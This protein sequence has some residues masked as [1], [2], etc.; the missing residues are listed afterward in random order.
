MYSAENGK[1]IVWNLELGQRLQEIDHVHCG[2]IISMHWIPS[3]QQVKEAFAVGYGDG[4]IYIYTKP[5]LCV[6][7]T[8]FG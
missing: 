8:S 5:T 3:Y 1:V 2:P 6:R 4:S 7:V